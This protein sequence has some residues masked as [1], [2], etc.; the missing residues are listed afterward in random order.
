MRRDRSA[1]RAGEYRQQ[2]I[3]FL[4]LARMTADPDTQNQL[5]KIAQRY[6]ALADAEECGADGERRSSELKLSS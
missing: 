1:D 4:K 2:A 5:I 3:S 6:R